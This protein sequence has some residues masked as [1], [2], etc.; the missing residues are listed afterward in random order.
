MSY[1]NLQQF[2]AAN[3][4]QAHNLASQ[5]VGAVQ[6]QDAGV[7]SGIKNQQNGGGAPGTTQNLGSATGNPASGGFFTPGQRSS[8]SEV[9]GGW[10]D[11]ANNA[12]SADTAARNLASAVNPNSGSPGSTASAQA[13]GGPTSNAAETGLNAA[14]LGY[15]LQQT[16]S[17]GG[18]SAMQGARPGQVNGSKG[19]PTGTQGSGRTPNGPLQVPAQ[20]TAGGPPGP[21][22]APGR[23]APTQPGRGATQQQGAPQAPAPAP[24]A[25]AS[26]QDI[27]RGAIPGAPQPGAVQGNP[28]G[29][30]QTP[31]QAAQN[32]GATQGGYGALL[33]QY[34]QQNLAGSVGNAQAAYQSNQQAQAA[35]KAQAAQA[36]AQAASDAQTAQQQQDMQTSQG[37]VD[38]IDNAYAGL[39]IP[40]DGST[41][42]WTSQLG[43][44]GAPPESWNNPDPSLNWSMGYAR[45]QALM[46]YYNAYYAAHP[47][48]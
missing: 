45:H 13:L 36:A 34:G 21:A 17:K 25:Q 39:A 7:M 12:L 47:K 32:T 27:A 1:V 3:K 14:L 33:A 18:P 28:A 48:Q 15:G 37:Q 30:S 22:P 19:A 46:D 2:Y 26:A 23:Q 41:N 11:V 38:A 29:P 31:A 8:K 42:D 9:A 40:G 4:D 43:P 35:A 5:A 44:D 6:Q 16:P 24:P 10:Q 20:Q